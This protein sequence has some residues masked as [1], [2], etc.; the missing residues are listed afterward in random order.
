M[1]KA[2][3]IFTPA[4][5]RADTLPR[6]YES[7]IRQSSF[8][9]CWMVIDDGS[10]DNT[11]QLVRSWILNKNLFEIIYIKKENGGL[12]TAYN[13]AIENTE[14]EL[15]MCIDSDDYAPDDLVEKVLDFWSKNG[16]D[17][18]AGIVGLDCYFDGTIVGDKLPEQKSVNLIDLLIGKYNLVNGDRANVVRTDLY[19]SVAPQESI[20]GEKNYNP[21]IM[22]LKISE[23]YDFLVMNENLKFIEYQ[24]DGMSNSIFRQY[25]NSPNSFLEIRRYY[26][27][28]PNIS[29]TFKVKN[30]I[31]YISSS[32]HAKKKGIIKNCH[33]KGLA[34]LLFLPGVLFSQYVV[35]MAKKER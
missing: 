19:K 3:T 13:C 6:L 7:L 31:H 33:Y 29:F 30:I 27:S 32:I 5:N 26:L 21:H 28:L 4:Y 1:K 8:D 9:F 20:N 35:Y 18:Y 34:I 25:L 12:H 17:K 16:C 11:E 10:I 23:K 22:H 2:L 14:T 24:T 15:M